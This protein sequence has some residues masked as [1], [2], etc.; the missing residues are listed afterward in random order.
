MWL[1]NVKFNIYLI[2][3]TSMVSDIF[4]LEAGSF[5]TAQS[6]LKLVISMLLS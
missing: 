3:A 6:G 1:M 2:Q 4:F 5:S